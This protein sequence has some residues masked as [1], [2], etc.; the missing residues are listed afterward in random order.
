MKRDEIISKLKKYFNIKELVCPHVASKFGETAWMFLSTQLLHTLLILR[1]D[2]IK[3]PMTINNGSTFT[4]R[5]LRC[6]MCQIVKGK[7]SPYLSAHVLGEG[8]DFSCSDIS[9]E[10]VR[11]LIAA[12]KD[13]LPYNIR[14]ESD[15]TWVHVDCYDNNSSKITYFKG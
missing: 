2:I 6:N 3:R 14:L 7:S 13:K 9:A 8:V 10:E 15:V 12:D 5:G 4:Q 11:K 1:E